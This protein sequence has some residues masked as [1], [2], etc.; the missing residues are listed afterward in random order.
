MVHSYW[1]VSPPIAVALAGVPPI[2]PRTELEPRAPSTS[3]ATGHEMSNI[4]FD[5]NQLRIV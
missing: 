1:L 5:P 3:C 4:N 2:F